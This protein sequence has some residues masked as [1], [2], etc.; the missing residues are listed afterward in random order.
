MD[1]LDKKS[2]LVTLNSSAKANKN[3]LYVK[4][5]SITDFIMKEYS[6]QQEPLKA[7]ILNFIESIQEDK[8]PEVTG[9]DGLSALKVCSIIEQEIQKN[10]SN[11]TTTMA[12]EQIL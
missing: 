11:Q 1:F 9:Q 7:E 10:L 5:F 12:M 4:G 2:N 6:N 3:E 8:S